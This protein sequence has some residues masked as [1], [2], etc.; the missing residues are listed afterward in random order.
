ML[1]SVG[2]DGA[3]LSKMFEEENLQ[4]NLFSSCDQ[5]WIQNIFFVDKPRTIKKKISIL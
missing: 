1:R 5:G 4:K 2:A 3:H